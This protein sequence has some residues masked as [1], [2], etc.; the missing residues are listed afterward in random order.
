MLEHQQPVK[1]IQVVMTPRE[2]KSNITIKMKFHKQNGIQNKE[3]ELRSP[4]PPSSNHVSLPTTSAANQQH[5][6]RQ[7]KNLSLP[8][9]LIGKKHSGID[10]K[11]SHRSLSMRNDGIY[12]VKQST[13]QP[14]TI[15]PD[16]TPNDANGENRVDPHTG[17]KNSQESLKKM[18]INESEQ[19]ISNYITRPVMSGSPLAAVGFGCNSNDLRENMAGGAASPTGKQP[20]AY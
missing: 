4:A 2:A 17:L 8:L 7:D 6:K 19:Q 13:M 20:V 11:M 5:A 10:G 12:N 3:S 9:H 1:S 16:M 15:T 14:Q 18:T